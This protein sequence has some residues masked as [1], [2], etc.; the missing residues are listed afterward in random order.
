MTEAI[1]VDRVSKSFGPTRALADVSLTIRRGE[2][3][4]LI[5]KNGAGKSTLMSILTGLVSPDSGV[6]RVLDDEGHDNFS[7][8]GCVYQRSTLV[9]GATAAENISLGRYPRRRGLINWSSV[10]RNAL[11]ALAEWGCAH[12]ADRVVDQLDP[13][14]RKVVEICRVLAS[15]PRVLLLDEP[16]AGL[17]RA[18]AQR[19][20]EQMAEAHK[21]GVTT[22]YVSHHLH[23]VF[24]VCDS[25]TVLRDGRLV[26]TEKLKAL[27]MT[28]LVEAMVGESVAEQTAAARQH[29]LAGQHAGNDPAVLVARE[30]TALP[31]VRQVD[32]ELR[33]GECVG[34]TGLDGAGHMQ[35]AEVLTGQRA[36]D[37]GAVT[38]EGRPLPTGD[39]RR[40]IAAGIGYTPEDRHMS[41]YIPGLSVAE[42]ATLSI[43]SQFTNRFGVLNFRKRDDFYRKL[44]N[45][46][47]I[48]AHSPGQAV[49]ELSGGNQQ[50]V[51]LARSVAA[52]PKVLVLMNPTAG[53]DVSA[54]DSIYSTIDDLKR[55]G[56]SVLLATSDDGDLEICDRILVMFDG[57]VVA[58]MH[59]PFSE[60]EIAAAVQGPGTPATSTAPAP[61]HSADME[62]QP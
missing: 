6:V 31:K 20:F 55:A 50:K 29:R 32:L 40:C 52:D 4:G 10:R 14:E 22:I 54:K 16:T 62:V 33:A 27:S 38:V 18:A 28:D 58:E 9:P 21:R 30:L 25:V 15:G 3:R 61:D 5:G 2:S 48:K 44:A 46:W 35:V 36:P 7:T 37:S 17:D 24:E 51:V 60:T 11:D 45:D 41:G 56:Q 1:T 12:L 43:L 47:S 57:E 34:L 42:N 49:E 19:L 23:E 39:I 59:P 8:V 26:L 13:L 53:V